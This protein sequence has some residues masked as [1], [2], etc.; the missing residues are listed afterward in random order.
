[1]GN[2]YTQKIDTYE[3]VT[4]DFIGAGILF[5]NN[6]VV[7]CGFT[8]EKISGIG[9]KKKLSDA[10]SYTKTAVRETLEELFGMCTKEMIHAATF[11]LPHDAPDKII[12]D[13]TH[14]Y[15]TIILNFR[16]LE[17]MLAN[18][19]KLNI[20]SPLYKVFPSTISELIFNRITTSSDEI[21]QLCLLPLSSNLQ[22]A[23]EFI[24]D[25]IA[26]KN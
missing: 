18:L 26:L 19:Q 12:F 7:L 16:I 1:M 24:S 6:D 25:L 11:V 23:Q 9:G 21:K 17:A 10:N 2:C 3:L 15:I 13:E 20:K 5:T 22:I 4:N 8:G 14:S